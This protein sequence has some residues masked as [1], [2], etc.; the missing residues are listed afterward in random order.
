VL[1]ESRLE[2]GEAPAVRGIFDERRVG[3][4]PMRTLDQVIRGEPSDLVFVRRDQRWRNRLARIRERDAR[5]SEFIKLRQ[6]LRRLRQRDEHSV[7]TPSAGQRADPGY[8]GGHMPVVLL[9]ESCDAAQ[10][11]IRHSE[12]HHRHPPRA[13]V[14]NTSHRVNGLR[15]RG[16]RILDKDT[17]RSGIG[18][19]VSRGGTRIFLGGKGKRGFVESSSAKARELVGGSLPARNGAL[20]LG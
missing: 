18:G 4:T 2:G 12:R 6:K 14:G 11:R 20:A 13:A 16:R 3:E 19:C 9:R 5:H 7:A 1:R 15:P 8:V 10:R 17:V